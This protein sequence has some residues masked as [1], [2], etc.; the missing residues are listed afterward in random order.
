MGVNGLMNLCA[1]LKKI[2]VNRGGKLTYY[3][4]K[5][6]FFLKNLISNEFLE[7]SYKYE[8]LSFTL[9]RFLV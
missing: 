5:L 1:K 3:Y 6:I 2:T 7:S 4:L 8:N 9:R